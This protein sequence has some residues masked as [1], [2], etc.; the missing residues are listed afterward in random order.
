MVELTQEYKSKLWE[1]MQKYWD[2]KKGKTKGDPEKAKKEINKIQELLGLDVTDFEEETPTKELKEYTDAQAE[3]QFTDE[4]IEKF[5]KGV[6]R[7]IALKHLLSDIIV[8]HYPKLKNNAPGI[9][10][11]VNITYD[12]IKEEIRK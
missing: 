5:E 6:V 3:E 1:N 12:L 9:G 7:A 11:V 10:Q 8:K 2:I 4:E